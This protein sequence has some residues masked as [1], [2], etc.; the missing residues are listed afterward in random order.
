MR[1]M[2]YSQLKII[3]EWTDSFGNT[4]MQIAIAYQSTYTFLFK[5][6]FKYSLDGGRATN[7]MREK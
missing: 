3:F 2:P 1:Q 6:I 5:C 7:E 4:N